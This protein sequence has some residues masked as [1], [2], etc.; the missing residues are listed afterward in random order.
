MCLDVCLDMC[1]ANSFTKAFDMRVLR[2]MHV[3]I[4]IVIAVD[5]S[6]VA[7]CEPNPI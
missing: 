1:L 5:M 6:V 7:Q 3:D 4:G 2:D